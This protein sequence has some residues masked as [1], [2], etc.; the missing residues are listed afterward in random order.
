MRKWKNTTPEEINESQNN[1]I[2]EWNMTDEHNEKIFTKIVGLQL[3]KIR[4]AKGLTQTKV[5]KKINVTFQQIQKY[6]RG[7]NE[8]RLI[9]IKKLAEVFNVEE[10]YFYKPITDR[11]LRFINNKRGING[12]PFESE[13]L[14]R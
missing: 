13:N 14:A 8:I 10:N 5:S 12:Y 6:E 1:L 9:F 4:L 3:K 2:S 7:A 11:D